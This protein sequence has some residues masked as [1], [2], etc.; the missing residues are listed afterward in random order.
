MLVKDIMLPS[1][2]TVNPEQSARE[3]WQIIS[4]AGLIGVPVTDHGGRITGIVSRDEIINAGPRVLDDNVK[5]RDIMQREVCILKEDAPL[6]DAWTLPANV[7][8]VVDDSGRFTG[9]LDRSE[10]GH[11]LFKMA[12]Q[13]LQQ[14]ETIL[15]SAHNGIVAIDKDGIVTTFNLAAEKIT[16]RRK[17]E[18]LGRHLSQVIIPQGLLDILEHGNYQSQYKFSVEYSSGT[19]I[20]LTNRSPIIENGRVVGAIGV[21]QDI[22]EFEF[23]SEELSSVKQLNR[24]LETIIESSYDGIIITDRQGKII[25]AN[26]AHERI[27]GLPGAS[28]Q[29]KTMADLVTAGVYAR[30]VVDAVVEQNGVVTLSQLTAHRN[31]LLI[32][33]NPVYNQRGEIER[34]VI[35]IRDMSD[36]NSLK[37]QLEQSIALSERYRGELNQLRSKLIHQTGMIVKSTKMQKV[38]EMALRLAQ[39]DTT[40]LLLGE[41]GVGKEVVAKTIHKNSKRGSGPFITVNCGAIPE[42][43]LESEMF[44][45]EKGA[46]TGAGREG[47]PGM[48]ELADNGTLFLDEIGDLPLLFQVKLLR[49]LQEREITRIGGTKSR[50][51]DVRIIAATNKQLEELVKEGK[52]RE[53]L[54]F[55]LN[56][57]PITIPPLRERKDDIIPLVYWFKKQFEKLYNIKKEFAPA[58]FKALVEYHW[59]GNVR[60]VKNVVERLLVTSAGPV[61]QSVEI[62]LDMAPPVLPEQLPGGQNHITVRGI[63]PLKAAQLELERQLIGAALKELGSTYK[64]ARALQVDQSTIVR[65]VNRLREQGLPL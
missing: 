21:F 65:K 18:A 58:V 27:T 30:S 33:G 12:A 26:K 22:S 50:P 14:A 48:F 63:I 51:V 56:V 43:L 5:V 49:A 35:N 8:P 1:N 45:Y 61:I 7:I 39:V 44:G 54:Y 13:M 38:A 55:R 53:D 16:R 29:G 42:N 10:V 59:P 60:E 23:I 34:V 41:S 3:A 46:F 64:A 2:T 9:I 25:R 28:I 15:D 6:S 47:K 17:S 4:R 24:E 19:H 36:L 11:T 57:V 37:N 40:V 52:F 32:T 20:Y 62:P 31:Q